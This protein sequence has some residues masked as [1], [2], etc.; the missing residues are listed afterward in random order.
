MALVGYNGN[1][2][3]GK[4]G[5]PKYVFGND[6]GRDWK[7]FQFAWPADADE[8]VAYMLAESDKADVYCAAELMH[9]DRLTASRLSR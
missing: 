7:P 8:A 2:I 1:W 5:K 9:G 4:N 6:D 3:A